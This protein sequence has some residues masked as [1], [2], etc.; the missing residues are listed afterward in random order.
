MFSQIVEAVDAVF[1]RIAAWATPTLV[2]EDRVSR[3]WPMMDTGLAL[4]G[5]AFYLAIVLVGY[6]LRPSNWRQLPPPK[7][8]G[9]KGASLAVMWRQDKIRVFQIV[10][11]CTQVRP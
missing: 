1:V 10:Y 5:T 9:A 2:Y 7:D 11:N 6:V 8:T 3:D 4:A